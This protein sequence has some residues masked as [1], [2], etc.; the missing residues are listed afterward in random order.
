MSNRKII[1]INEEVDKML[2]SICDAALK[3]AGM[4][5]IQSV[6]SVIEAVVEESDYNDKI[7]ID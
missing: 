4:Q 3:G 5:I 6:N 1:V 7:M 2:G